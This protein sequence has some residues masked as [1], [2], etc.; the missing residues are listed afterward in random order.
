MA[1]GRAQTNRSTSKDDHRRE[2]RASPN[3]FKCDPLLAKEHWWK[4]LKVPITPKMFWPGINLY[5]ALSKI[6]QKFL[7]LVETSIFGE[8]SK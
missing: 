1:S 8:F 4:S 3:K 5:I 6:P 2:W 7:H